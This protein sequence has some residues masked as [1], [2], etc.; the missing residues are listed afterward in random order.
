MTNLLGD[1][2]ERVAGAS[3]ASWIANKMAATNK[4]VDIPQGRIVRALSK[5]CPFDGG[6][7]AFKSIQESVKHETL[8]FVDESTLNGFPKAR[9]CQYGAERRVGAFDCA[10]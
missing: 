8:A 5:L 6:E 10:S 4:L 2:G 9:L 7:F 1:L 3:S